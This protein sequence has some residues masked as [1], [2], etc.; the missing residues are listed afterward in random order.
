MTYATQAELLE[1]YGESMLIDLTDRAD[2]PANVIDATVVARGLTDADAEIDGYL[3]TKYALPL[4][5]TPD[6]VRN[7]ALAIAI[8]KLHRNTVSDKVRQ[9]YEDARSTLKLISEGKMRLNAAGIEPAGNGASGVQITDR[10][11][12]LTA[13]NLKGFI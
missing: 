2:P 5:A 6:L 9:D 10:E 8:Y 12:P 11:R 7:L 13:E 1:R 3:A 4:Q